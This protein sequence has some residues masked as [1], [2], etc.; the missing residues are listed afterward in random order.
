[1]E[2][3]SNLLTSNFGVINSVIISGFSL[4]KFP[5]SSPIFL[6][7]YF[8]LLLYSFPLSSPKFIN[9]KSSRS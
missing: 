1:M 5:P 2:K 3:G 9:E 4:K 6:R 8:V 7:P